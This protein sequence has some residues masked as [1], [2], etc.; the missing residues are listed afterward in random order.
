MVLK[1]AFF[2]QANNFVLFYLKI[3]GPDSG[4]KEVGSNDETE[5]LSN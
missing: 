2:W 1:Y 5:C 3:N 4:K